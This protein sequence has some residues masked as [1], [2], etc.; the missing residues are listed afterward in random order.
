[1]PIVLTSQ[2]KKVLGFIAVMVVLGLLVLGTKRLTTPESKP[3]ETTVF[4]VPTA[5]NKAP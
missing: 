1:M 2:E 5:V 4:A 3:G